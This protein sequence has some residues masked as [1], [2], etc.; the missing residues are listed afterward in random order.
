MATTE[1]NTG[2][3][4]AKRTSFRKYN[5]RDLL[6]RIRRKHP[7]ADIGESF[8]IFLE[9]I[10][11]K[12]NRKYVLAIYEYWHA[13][14]YRALSRE[15]RGTAKPAISSAQLA[16]QQAV[17]DAEAESEVRIF[18]HTILLDFVMPNGKQLR[19]CTFEYCGEI[20]GWFGKIAEAGDPDQ[21]VGDVL[22][23][24]ALQQ[25]L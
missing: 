20:G 15:E 11:K 17:F 2:T 14:A 23:E 5:P 12:Q 18:E 25:L 16:E 4:G 24:A 22:S 6:L 8:A 3:Q 13:N 9:E 7:T 19:A 1:I 21:V 10:E